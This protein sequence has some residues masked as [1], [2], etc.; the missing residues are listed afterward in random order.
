MTVSLERMSRRGGTDRKKGGGARSTSRRR[1][2]GARE[3]SNLSQVE[4][5]CL[6]DSVI[7]LPVELNDCRVLNQML[8]VAVA[9]DQ[10]V[11]PQIEST[12]CEKGNQE[13]GV[14]EF[15]PEKSVQADD[16]GVGSQ[17][18]AEKEGVVNEEGKGLD[19]ERRKA[20]FS[21]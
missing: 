20:S 12:G 21:G 2:S 9:I 14:V 6:H 3:G 7:F 17:D 11:T 15:L 13:H 10:V 16:Y 5:Q 18:L 1:R 19:R 4:N 8:N